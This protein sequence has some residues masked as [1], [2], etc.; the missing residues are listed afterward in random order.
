MGWLF[1]RARIEP[2]WLAVS[3]RSGAIDF[4]H[5]RPSLGGD[6]QVD[7]CGTRGFGSDGEAAARTASD[8]EF[9]R[10]QCSTL[11]APSE[12]QMLLVDAPKVPPEEL[13][14]AVRWHIKDMID[15]HVDDAT[16]DVLD[17]PPD[18]TGGG[19]NHSMY[20]VA[21]RN[22]VIRSCIDRFERARIALS[23]IEVPETAQRNIAALLE[24]EGRGVAMLYVGPEHGLLTVNFGGELYLSRRIDVGM[25]QIEGTP[26]LQRGD[27]FERVA[28]ELQRTFDHFDRQYPSVPIAMLAL[29]PQ[30]QDTGLADFL[31]KHLDLSV[32]PVRLGELIAFSPR[33]QL[34]VEGEWRLFHLVGAALRQDAKAL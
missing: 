6:I 14:T 10:Y 30:P 21:A 28:L 5:G 25:Q 1:S 33:S 27:I 26:E 24:P 7:R 23:V 13:R 8:L 18:P 11:L 29:A 19:R 31:A 34:D 9:H 22:E 17:I 32:Q 3:L 2:G 4:A 16:V 12:Y 20:V 15:Y